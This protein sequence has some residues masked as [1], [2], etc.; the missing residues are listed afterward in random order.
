MSD[1]MFLP[2]LALNSR[3][4]PTEKLKGARQLLFGGPS[5]IL[6]QGSWVV[7]RDMR[8]CFRLLPICR[9]SPRCC[10]GWARNRRPYFQSVDGEE[11]LRLRKVPPTSRF[12]AD[13]DGISTPNIRVAAAIYFPVGSFGHTGFTGTSM[14]MDPFTDTYVILFTNSG[15]SDCESQRLLRFAARSRV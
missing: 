8:V 6:H 12:C 4:A 3:I 9:S 7:W 11:S 15:P 5:T 13:L 10:S 1:T 14:W 2:P